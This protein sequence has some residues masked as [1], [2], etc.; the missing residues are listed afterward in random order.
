M[1]ETNRNLDFSLLELIELYAR[2]WRWL[3]GALALAVALATL[4]VFLILKPNYTAT[5]SLLPGRSDIVQRGIPILER[6]NFRGSFRVG[7]ITTRNSMNLEMMVST[8]L[9][10]EMVDSLA[11]V[12]FFGFGDLAIRQPEKARQRAIKAMT[13]ATHFELS[14]QLQVL[15]VHVTTPDSEMSARIANAYLEAVAELNLV[16]YR[17]FAVQRIDF[18]ERRLAELQ[19]LTMEAEQALLAF[20]GEKSV[21]DPYLERESLF[22]LKHQLQSQLLQSQLAAER[23]ALDAGESSP[24]LL[25]LRAEEEIY[26]SMLTSLSTEEG[27]E[28]AGETMA[29]L[30]DPKLGLEWSK[31]NRELRLLEDLELLLIEE[32]EMAHLQSEL[33][34]ETITVLDHAVAPVDPVGPSRKLIVL[35]V[36]VCALILISTLVFGVELMSRIGDGSTRTGFRRFLGES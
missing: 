27:G 21:L 16:R 7:N 9:R 36:A 1:N 29:N 33:D 20:Q 32:R 13:R 17:R 15:F 22:V 6:G 10:A 4:Y 31:L 18:I 5:A 23:I 24:Q 28:P 30:I 14:L 2:R 34:F 3:L 8:T 35:A 26:R 11:L 19:P 25:A 12:E